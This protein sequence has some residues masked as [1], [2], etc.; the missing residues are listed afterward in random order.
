MQ[1]N[2]SILIRSSLEKRR[3]PKRPTRE[4]ILFIENKINKFNSNE[5]M[6]KGYVKTLANKY[7]HKKNKTNMWL[8]YFIL[9]YDVFKVSMFFLWICDYDDLY[10]IFYV[11]LLYFT[12]KI[13]YVT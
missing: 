5:I 7:K 6:I 3:V 9:W 4:R 13:L 12:I 8:W 10:F 1:T 11:M 2:T